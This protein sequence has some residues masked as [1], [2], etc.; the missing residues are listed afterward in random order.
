VATLINNYIGKHMDTFTTLI[1]MRH[2]IAVSIPST[3]LDNW[4]ER[5]HIGSE[6]NKL[7]RAIEAYLGIDMDTEHDM[8]ETLEQLK[9][10]YSESEGLTG[11]FND[12][13]VKHGIPVT[14]ID[15]TI[16]A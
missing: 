15:E 6:Y 5:L 16:A 12:A 4:T 3:R 14:L 8:P 11:I 7:S 9:A 10:W 1:N 2:D 13:V